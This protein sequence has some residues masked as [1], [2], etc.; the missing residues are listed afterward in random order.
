MSSGNKRLVSLNERLKERLIPV[1]FCV[2]GLVLAHHD[3]VLSG[4]AVTQS[5]LGDTRFAELVMEHFWR[6]LLGYPMHG[7]LWTPPSFYPV[8]GHLVWN[9]N[10]IGAGLL[11]VPF[12]ALGLEPD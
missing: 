8:T 3:M 1:V 6:W 4:F 5:D 2:G 11:Y 9:E 10:M 12:R 7:D